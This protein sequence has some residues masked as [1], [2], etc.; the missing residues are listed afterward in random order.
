[1]IKNINDIRVYGVSFDLAMDIFDCTKQY[2]K[3][4]KY[5]LTDQLRR[6]SR[7]IVANISEGWGKRQYPQTLKR[8][9]IDSLGSLEET[10]TWLKF[11]LDCGYLPEEKFKELF[12]RCEEVGSKLWVLHKNWKD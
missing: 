5:S 9:L 4:E 2:P 10:K 7:S 11:S 3:E 12:S 6:S 1:M 8:H